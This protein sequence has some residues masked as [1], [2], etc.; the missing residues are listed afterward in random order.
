MAA[1]NS[2]SIFVFSGLFATLDHYFVRVPDALVWSGVKLFVRH[3]R[4]R[5]YFEML[6]IINRVSRI[7][8]ALTP[9]VLLFIFSKTISIE[10]LLITRVYSISKHRTVTTAQ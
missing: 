5:E 1:V 7:H 6:F 4:T 9:Q 3:Y 2:S 8:F 10:I